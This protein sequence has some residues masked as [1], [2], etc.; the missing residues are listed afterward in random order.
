MKCKWCC[1]GT[2]H[3]RAL[4]RCFAVKMLKTRNNFSSS[5]KFYFFYIFFL[6]LI[7]LFCPQ[8]EDSKKCVFLLLFTYTFRS[9]FFKLFTLFWLQNN[10]MMAR[11]CHT[12]PHSKQLLLKTL[13]GAFF[14]VSAFPL[15]AYKQNL[16][17]N[18]LIPRPLIGCL[19]LHT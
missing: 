11:Y 1:I 14:F 7:L 2:E 10:Y 4:Q 17:S 12:A 5:F 9:Q 8:S 13:L 19:S 16:L 18:T 15:W 3:E 6:V